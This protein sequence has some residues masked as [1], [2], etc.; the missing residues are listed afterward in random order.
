MKLKKEKIEKKYKKDQSHLM[1]DFK[2][3]TLVM[4]LR[5]PHKKQTLK[6]TK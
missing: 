4:S 3:V 1:L 5:Q 6:I 2:T